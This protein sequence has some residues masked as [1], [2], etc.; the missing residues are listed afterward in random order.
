MQ[1]SVNNVRNDTKLI[2][3]SAVMG[4]PLRIHINSITSSKPL[5]WYS[6]SSQQILAASSFLQSPGLPLSIILSESE[7][8]TICFAAKKLIKSVPGQDYQL[9]QAMLISEQAM[10]LALSNPLLFVLLVNY[11]KKHNFDAENFKRIVLRKRAAILREM[12]L[13]DSNSAVRILARTPV[14]IP[15]SS[16][17]STIAWML[18]DEQLINMLR[19]LRNSSVAAFIMAYKQTKKVWPALLDMLNHD[20]SYADI[21]ELNQIVDD[22]RRMGA[23]QKQLQRVQN[24]QQLKQLHDRLVERFNVEQTAVQLAHYKNIYGQYPAPP[25]PGTEHIQAVTSWEELMR[26]G[27]EMRHCVSSYHQSIHNRR[28]FIYRVFGETRLTL[29]INKCNGR[30]VLGELKGF[31]NSLPSSSDKELVKKWLLSQQ[32]WGQSA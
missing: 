25:L 17:I 29:S 1:A 4:Y 27:K 12:G 21:G 24:R 2:D 7:Q 8:E 15:Y 11:A 3:M 31:A 23:S 6:H 30:W 32:R 9:L 14:Y 19:H 16:S 5:F 28:V 10:E 26:E 20:S 18:E 13:I 22:C